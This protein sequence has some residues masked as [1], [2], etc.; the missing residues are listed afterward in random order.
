M[1]RA[2]VVLPAFLAVLCVALLAAGR[3]I[4][5]SD[6]YALPDRRAEVQ[7]EPQPPF[8]PLPPEHEKYLDQ[9]LEYWEFSSSK[10]ERYRC[11]FHRWEYDP[12]FGPRDTYKT[13]SEG[14]IK[15]AAPDKGL[16]QVERMRHYSPPEREGGESKYVERPNEHGEFW[17]CDG[18]SVF[19]FDYANETL[20]E[21]ELPPELRG[22]AIV[23]GPL[24]FLFGAK[25]ESIKQRYWVRVVTPR[26]AEGEY[27]LEAYPKTRHDAANYKKV[28]VIIDERDFLPKALQIYDVNYD[29]RTHPSRTV[30]S[31]ENREINWR[32][33][34]DLDPLKLFTREF[35]RPSTP[36]GWK[37][38]VIPYDEEPPPDSSASRGGGRL[39]R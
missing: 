20:K 33:A 6:N 35:H 25:A 17:I 39:P 2:H 3:S 32:E 26:E 31:F 34:A 11:R 29:V 37:K 24:P 30:L 4:A 38:V 12:V 36:R 10:I 18:Q 27:W 23:D 21:R 1:I 8:G 9:I 16:F 14:V 5:Q 13:L 22:K 15:Y 19:E 28:E 7:E